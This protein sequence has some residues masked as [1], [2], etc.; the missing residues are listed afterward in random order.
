MNVAFSFSR[1]RYGFAR[2]VKR[3]NYG[4]RFGIRAFRV[5]RN[6]GEPIAC[7]PSPKM[8]FTDFAILSLSF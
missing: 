6:P 1:G 8:K 4:P 3:S 2:D 5:E 7:I